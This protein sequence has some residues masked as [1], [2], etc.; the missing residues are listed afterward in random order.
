MADKF[1]KINNWNGGISDSDLFGGKG[2][3]AEIVGCDFRS[4]P[5][6]I[7]PSQALTKASGTLVTDFIKH[8]LKCSTGTTFFFG[9]SGLIYQRTSAGS[10]GTVYQDANGTITGCGELDGYIYWAST[11]TLSRISTGSSWATEVDHNWATLTSATSHQMLVNGLYLYILNSRNVATVDDTGTITLTGTP[12]VNLNTLP[13]NYK[14]TTISNYGIDLILGTEEISGVETSRILRWDTVSPTWN[15]TDDIPESSINAF[16]SINNFLLVQGGNQGRL[17]FYNGN[18]LEPF[19]KIQGDYQNKTM[20]VNSASVC[21]FQGIAL[22]GVSNVSGNPCNMG[23]YSLGQYDR[24]YPMALNLEYVPSTGSITGMEFGKLI[25]S[26]T[27]LC[28]AWK[29]GTEYGIDELNWNSKYT[30]AYFKT[31]QISGDRWKKKEFKEFNLSY[32]SKPTSTDITLNYYKN[33]GTSLGTISLNDQTDYNKM[34][35]LN[36]F[37]VGTNQFRVNF[38]TSGNNAPSLEELYCQWMEKDTL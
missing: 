27:S 22:F 21:Q 36:S 12:D 2:S 34:S 11:G 26:G 37:E 28:V 35:N 8:G 29:H 24:S 38:T 16:I 5:G 33:Y 18:E 6:T 4:E 20:T 13:S 14:Y 17:Y 31:L 15:T 7:K 23:V 25:S 1:Y 30:G 32:K 10:Y 3:L 19:K 9:S